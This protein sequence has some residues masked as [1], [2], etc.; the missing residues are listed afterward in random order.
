MGKFYKISIPKPCHEDWNTMTPSEKGRFCDS[1]AKTVI[2]FTTMSSLHIQDF[3]AEN[4]NQK[5]CGH[6]KK[7]QLDTIHLSIPIQVIK[8]R[9]TFGRSF[10]LALLIAMG[11][12]LVN[13]TNHDGELQKIENVEIKEIIPSKKNCTV[14][15]DS[16]PEKCT[17]S[18]FLTVTK[19]KE[20]PVLELIEEIPEEIIPPPVISDPI[21]TVE[22]DI[23][24]V[25]GDLI[26][27][28]EI[29]NLDYPIPIH[30]LDTS[31][32]LSKTPKEKRTQENYSK[33]MKK[34]I[35]TYFNTD[36]GKKLGL[37]GT[38]RIYVRYEINK[39]GIIKDIKIRAPHPELKK[40]AK[41]VLQ[42]IPKLIAGTYKNEPVRTLYH[43][44]IVFKIEE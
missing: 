36:I 32:S 17:K 42:K 27:S 26:A 1:C 35:T 3:L 20:D 34:F 16:I 2:D 25:M 21:E 29:V 10:M 43:L 15:I 40:E 5:I 23:E 4:Q 41:R 7:T 11:T 12:T 38:Q 9:Q 19:K 37:K 28:N 30:L 6:F 39:D 8:T 18:T 44:P 33:Q 14:S 31:P 13:C 22:G 24:I